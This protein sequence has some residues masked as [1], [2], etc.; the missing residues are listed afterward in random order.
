MSPATRSIDQSVEVREVANTGSVCLN[1][2][3]E[4]Y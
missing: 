3:A 1:N 4:T 2:A